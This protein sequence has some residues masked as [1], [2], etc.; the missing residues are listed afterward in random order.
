MLGKS[1][2]YLVILALSLTQTSPSYSPVCPGDNVTVTCTGSAGTVVWRTGPSL[3]PIQIT[4]MSDTSQSLQQ[5]QNTP[6]PAFTVSLLSFDADTNTLTSIA[7]IDGVT[8]SRNIQ[9]S[10][11]VMMYETV[12]IVVSGMI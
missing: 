3:A 8:I 5:T 1:Y 9:C 2:V 4:S 10:E 11:D 7:T 12:Q 6:G